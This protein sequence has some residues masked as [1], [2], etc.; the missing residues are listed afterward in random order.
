MIFSVKGY[1]VK[2]EKVICSNKNDAQ[3][4]P[5]LFF[6]LDLRFASSLEGYNPV[7][8][9]GILKANQ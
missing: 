5:K 2:K 3:Y 1:I 8:A 7:L 9:S 6:T 4:N